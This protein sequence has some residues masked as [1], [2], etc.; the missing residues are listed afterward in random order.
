[1]LR[2]IFMSLMIIIILL[3]S[4]VMPAATHSIS[5]DEIDSIVLTLA[6]TFG[7]TDELTDTVVILRPAQLSIAVQS[8]RQHSGDILDETLFTAQEEDF[9]PL[10]LALNSADFLNMP[11]YIDTGVLDGHFARITIN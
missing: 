3:L 10:L 2:N 9:T 8:V 11:E 1:M 6:P 7:V 5:A 4:L